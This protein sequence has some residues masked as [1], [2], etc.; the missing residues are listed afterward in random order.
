MKDKGRSIAEVS[1][2]G[3]IVKR[4]PRKLDVMEG[5][6]AAFCVETR[7]AIE[8]IRWSRNGLE[9]RETPCTVLKSFGKTHLLVLVHVT[10]EDAGVISFSVGESQT[11]AQLRIKCAKRVPPSAPVAAEMSTDRSNAALLT[12]CPGPDAHRTPPSS[13]VLERQEASTAEWVQCLTTDLASMV[14]VL[15]D[16]VPAEA[17][18]CFRICAVNKYGRSRP[19]EFPGSVHLVPVACVRR[20]LKDVQVQAGQDAQFSLELSAS[21]AGS[22]FLNG[23]KLKE[24]EEGQ[25]CCIKHSGMEHSLLLHSVPLAES[26]AK[27]TFVSSGVRDSAT[28]HVQEPPVRIVSSNEDAAHTYLASERVV[29]VCELSRADALVQWYKDGVEVEEDE[30]LLLEREGPHHRL[31]IPSAHPQDT[32]EFVCDTGGDSVFYNITVTEPPVRIVSSNEDAAHI[33]LASERVVL[34]CE[35]SHADGPV[36]WYKDGVEVEEGE[37]LLLEC[38]G[39]H[40]RL[41]IPLA[42]P[43]DT[44]EFVC[45]VGG[46][47]RSPIIPAGRSVTSLRVVLVCELSCADA[48][49]QWY[50]DGVEVEEDKHLL[51]E[52]EGSHH[53][54]V[55]PSAHPQDT[56]EF[57]CDAG[58]DSVFYNITVTGECR[59]LPAL[60]APT[61]LSPLFI[62]A[63]TPGELG[64]GRRSPPWEQG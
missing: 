47:S 39:P 45:N 8:G 36:Q 49:V 56:G 43:Q 6:N 7:D 38:E 15:G 48:P 2:R 20:A 34:A 24:E 59:L 3:A 1:V 35:L 26:G 19:V 32:G 64:A 11:S 22:W 41:V 53:R 16:S 58:G 42:H 29:L 9:L 52:R 25:R 55:I 31:V 17:D 60:A 50:K 62:A 51:L 44:G 13:Y 61:E 40:R 12:W 5:E 23:A 28:L 27:V 21:V 14:E 33:Y 57:V 4:L 18:Y 54:L 10:R 37:H 63:P 46:D 30:H